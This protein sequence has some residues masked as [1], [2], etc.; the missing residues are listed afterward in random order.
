MSP[1]LF[2]LFLP[3]PA[4][5]QFS[6]CIKQ[7]SGAICKSYRTI[8]IILSLQEALKRGFV[9]QEGIHHKAGTEAEAGD[10]GV[11]LAFAHE[12]G[13]GVEEAE[14]QVLVFAGEL[15]GEFFLQIVQSIGGLSNERCK[16]GSVE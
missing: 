15:P 10:E 13:V 2:D 11:Q 6:S 8:N 7:R 16:E 14:E 9:A 3:I 1:I 5:G 12:L 4:N